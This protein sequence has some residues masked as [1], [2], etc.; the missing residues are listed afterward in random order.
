MCEKSLFSEELQYILPI[1]TA[2]ETA[3]FSKLFRKTICMCKDGWSCPRTFD[4]CERVH[5]CTNMQKSQIWIH[6]Q[7]YLYMHEICV[8][9]LVRAPAHCRLKTTSPQWI[10]T[11]LTQNAKTRNCVG[12]CVCDPLH[13]CIWLGFQVGSI[14]PGGNRRGGGR[15]WQVTSSSPDQSEGAYVRTRKRKYTAR[16]W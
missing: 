2:M 16:T 3:P 7:T 5:I 14:A 13:L 6:R 12:G 1:Y 10:F 11:L 8:G 9:W 4:V 15:G